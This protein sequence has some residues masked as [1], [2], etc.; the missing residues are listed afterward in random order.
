[1]IRVPRRAIVDSDSECAKKQH[2]LQALRVCSA[3]H[4]SV[5][6]VPRRLE[7]PI[8]PSVHQ[9]VLAVQNFRPPARMNDWQAEGRRRLAESLQSPTRMGT[10]IIRRRWES[11]LSGPV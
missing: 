6:L 7:G 1:M 3:F 10:G 4:V 9:S 5:K 11:M 2:V 8:R